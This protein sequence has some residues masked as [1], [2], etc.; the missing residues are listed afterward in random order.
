MRRRAAAPAVRSISLPAPTGGLNAIAAGVA[1]PPEDCVLLYNLVASEYGLRSRLGSREWVTGLTG[2][3]DNLVRA[4]LPFTGSAKSG[5]QNKLFATTSS[6]IW[7]V[8]ASTSTPSLSIAFGTTTGDAGYGVCRTVVTSAGHFLLY[9]DEV[10]GLYVY[11]ESSGT[12]AKVAMGGGAGQISGFD[13]ANAVFVTVFKN[14][15]CLV[16]RDTA[17]FWYGSAGAI[18]GAFTSFELGTQF[19][20]GGP[21][22]GLWNWT[23]DGGSGLD[24]QLVG[25]SQGGDVVVYQGTD[26]NF[27]STVVLRGVWQVGAMPEGRHV[28]N[29]VGGDVLILSRAGALP[30][31]T[32]VRGGVLTPDDYVTSK[33]GPLFNAAML[34]KAGYK[35][36][37]IRQHPEDSTLLVTVPEGESQAT[38]QL[39]LSLGRKSWSRYRDL[40]MYC[41]ESWGGKLYYG[42]TDGKVGINDGYV[43][44][45]TLADPDAFTPVQW[46]L[47]TAFQNLG[48]GNTKQVVLIEPTFLCEGSTPAYSAD[49]RYDFDLSELATVSGG[50]SG[51]STWG[52]AVWD[53]AVWGGAYSNT[54]RPGGASGMGAAVAIALRG[55]AVARTVLVGID[56]DF[57]VGGR[58]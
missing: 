54:R 45:L 44:G 15:V 1:M 24:D 36:W 16:E 56:V 3:T 58:F 7:D 39:A 9:T 40:P 8:S 13:P 17:R 27:A 25:I 55:T 43:D 34:S 20:A 50:V 37:S 57:M 42:T 4:L 38:T 41:C 29:S 52:S 49:A 32:L 22:V 33:I 31:S 5:A 14:R 6:G 35:G 53:T 11:T 26:L 46:A 12:W 51:G 21:L 48:T 47:L 2:A 23:M 18:F 10:N 30:I 19:R 28:A